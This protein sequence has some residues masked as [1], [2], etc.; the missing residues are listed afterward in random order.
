[1]ISQPSQLLDP[2]EGSGQTPPDPR[3]YGN[4]RGK[5]P[6]GEGSMKSTD[7]GHVMASVTIDGLVLDATSRERL[8]DVINR[9]GVK[10]PQVCYHPQPGPIQTCDTCL[11]EIN[12]QLVRSCATTASEGMS[13]STVSPAAHA[14]RQEAFDRILSNHM[15]RDFTTREYSNC[16]EDC[17][18]PAARF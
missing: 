1:M 11:V 6:E 7:E 8:I 17:W 15:L 12:G 14:A 13:V 2:E 9:S 3:S 10:M 4:A 5:V 18:G 16:C